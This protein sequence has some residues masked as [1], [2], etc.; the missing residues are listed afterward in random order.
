MDGLWWKTLLKWMIWGYPYFWKHPNVYIYIL[1]KRYSTY[2][3][4]LE[5]ILIIWCII[6]EHFV[7]WEKELI[8]L[9]NSTFTV[10]DNI[11]PWFSLPF[12]RGWI[13]WYPPHGSMLRFGSFQSPE[14]Q[15]FFEKWGFGPDMV[16]DTQWDTQILKIKKKKHAETWGWEWYRRNGC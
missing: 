1:I 8:L 16:R 2:E 3:K 6:D 4:T 14:I 11:L 12:S 10:R 13:P 5:R 9:N 15:P 7:S